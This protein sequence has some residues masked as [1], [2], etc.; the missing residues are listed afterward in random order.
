MIK[1]HYIALGVV[2]VL[3]GVGWIL[4]SSNEARYRVDFTTV[5]KVWSDVVRDADEVGLTLTRVSDRK[6]IEFGVELAKRLEP[7]I[8]SDPK[9]QKYV[10]EV[11]QRLV[12]QVRRKN[13]KYQF[14]VINGFGINA[15]ALPGG[16]IY[17][18]KQMLDF[19]RSEA[20]LAAIMA[21]EINHVDLRHCIER[22]QYELLVRR[23]LP[24]DLAAIARLPYSLL[25]APYSKQQE[26][27]ADIDAV[28]IMAKAGYHPKYG[29]ALF[30]RLSALQKQTRQR[31]PPGSVTE[32]LG[33]AVWEALKEY[34]QTHPSWPDRIREIAGVLQ[35]NESQWINKT[36][37]VGRSNLAERMSWRTHP[38][39]SELRPY[40]EPPAFV[41]Y[42][43]KSKYPDFKAMAANIP[44]G[45]SGVASNEATP[46]GAIA[47]ARSQCEKM[48]K[49]C[50]LYALGDTVVVNMSKDQIDVVSSK[51][52]KPGR[53]ERAFRS[54]LSGN[55]FK[56]LAVDMESGRSGTAFGQTTPTRAIEEAVAR[57]SEGGRTCELYA[58]GD[59]VVHGL[60]KERHDAAIEQYRQRIVAQKIA[61]LQK[62]Y[63]DNRT[64][65]DFKALAV[66]YRSGRSAVSEAQ[67]TPLKA[68]E[69]AVALCSTQ[70]VACK[71]HAI[72]DIVVQGKSQN[73][74]NAIAGS[75]GREVIKHMFGA[76]FKTYLSKRD[77]K[78]FV[79]DVP[80]K[81]WGYTSARWHPLTSL[82]SALK[83]CR[84]KER[85]CEV[86]ALGDTFVLDLPR[87]SLA[88]MIDEYNARVVWPTDKRN[89]L[90]EYLT[91]PTFSDFKAFA[92]D[93]RQ[94]NWRREWGYRSPSKA[95][96]EAIAKCRAGNPS[97]ELY[98]VGNH[99]VYGQSEEEKKA[100]IALYIRKVMEK[101]LEFFRQAPYTDFKA[102]AGNPETMQYSMAYARASARDAVQEAMRSCAEQNAPCQ[103]FAV[104]EVMVFGLPQQRIDQ[105]IEQYQRDASASRETL[106]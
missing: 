7:Q 85:D 89:P 66:D 62:D 1:R 98:A 56:A 75:Y 77:F 48:I 19:V 65:T 52:L 94:R 93:P 10:S 86:A 96:E 50:Q 103:L 30:D 27:E 95:I 35:R 15:F 32:E 17:I 4:A 70:T 97:C 2:V 100:A 22:F 79:V 84:E 39:D 13:I 12:K 71:V 61:K 42:L 80:G 11:G 28:I 105:I 60:P 63:L 6:E 69:R 16:N 68:I 29:L 101:K 47:S 90:R 24:S 43:S 82:I 23:I 25:V 9:Q 41:D 91:E 18:T 55:D 49:P 92:A 3:L 14:H 58:V 57:C 106:K 36:F 33:T 31:T 46:S 99:I 21:H 44:S 87:D 38:V 51:Y 59:E 37:Y 26:R 20:E 45:L 54:Y 102:I 88:A 83:R 78:T 53:I 34:F 67:A 104:G 40:I 72:G 76:E 8:T 73:E 5:V 81:Y 74:R 64:Y